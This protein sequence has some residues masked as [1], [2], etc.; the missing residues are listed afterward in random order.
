MYKEV[1]IEGVMFE[2]VKNDQD[3]E[4]KSLRTIPLIMK[5]DVA[6]DEIFLDEAACNIGYELYG[7]FH[8]K[9]SA[10]LMKYPTKRN[11]SFITA[12]RAGNSF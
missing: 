5:R 6:L 11:R 10:V 7:P 12:N 4:V 2:R 9:H 1:P 8:N 3:G